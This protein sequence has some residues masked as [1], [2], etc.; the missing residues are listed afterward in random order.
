VGAGYMVINNGAISNKGV[1]LVLSAVPINTNN[2]VF[3]TGVNFS[4]NTSKVEDLGIANSIEIGNIWG[5][6]GPNMSV[7]A[8][9]SYGTI[10]GWDYIYE[11]GK[12]VVNDAGTKYL[13]TDERVPV[14]NTSPDF[15][16]GW[17]TEFKYKNFSFGTL[18]DAK[19]GGDIYSGTYVE[20]MAHGQSPATLLERN[21]GGLPYTDPD[22][23][24]SNIGVTL[25]GVY[26]N[27]EPN[28]KIVH[29][30]YKYLPNMGGWGTVITTP[31]ILENSWIKLRQVSM[32]YTLPPKIKNKIKIA[33]ELSV[34]LVLRDVCY[35]YTTL[36]DKI[37]PEGLMGSGNAQ[38]FEW[39]SLPGTM[40]VTFGINAKF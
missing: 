21:G 15:I 9:E 16:G 38:G 32:A 18:I 8:G 17:Y 29:Y 25:G 24:T 40:S 39:G 2:F 5:Q 19:I 14:G 6:N 33:Q 35:L 4:R 7:T 10:Y 23:N 26:E 34:S 30:Y 13:I 20:S 12:R 11:D 31:G 28:D 27:G 36:P 1:E 22:G 3:R 37:N